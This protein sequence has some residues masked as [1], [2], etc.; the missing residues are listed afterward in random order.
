MG[1]S[2]TESNTTQ[3]MSDPEAARRMAAVAERQQQMA[4][5]QWGLA[6]DIYLPYEQQMVASNQALVGENEALM[7]ARMVEG[8]RDIEEGRA[9]KDETRRQ[10]LEELKVSEPAVKAFYEEAT[11]PVDVAERE[12]EA[13]AG[14][15]SE[16]ANVPESIRR[17]MSRT[18]V[19]L[20]GARY[21][22]LMKAVALDRAKAIS[23]SRATARQGARDETLNRLK[24]A[25]AARS[26]VS[27][28]IDN[29]AYAQGEEQ[30]GNYTLKSAADRAAGL[31]GNAIQANQAGMS[32]LSKG[33][34][35]GFS[36]SF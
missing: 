17:Q 27:P 7:R 16:Y 33:S 8:T 19:N 15:V 30:L 31:Y 13:E 12:A 11:K 36:F 23:G 20:T 9:L 4:E 14:V 32:P 3:Q 21:Q 26:G 34:S 28:T 25:M 24:T 1:G 35:S 29:T 10:R 22:S 2:K 6:R 18:G 5:E